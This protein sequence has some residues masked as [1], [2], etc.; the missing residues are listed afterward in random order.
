MNATEILTGLLVVITAIY[1]WTTWRQLAAMREALI[2]TR[3]SNDATDKSN[4]I[5]ERSLELGMR[6]WVVVSINDTPK[7]HDAGGLIIEMSNLGGIPA[8]NGEVWYRF[9]AWET[10]EIPEVIPRGPY[11]ESGIVIGS[12]RTHIITPP[13]ESWSP[14]FRNY[15]ERIVHGGLLVTFYCEVSYFD[16]FGKERKTIAC[17]RHS[18]KTTAFAHQSWVYAPKHNRLE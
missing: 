10:G 13:W 2:E 18:P 1:A 15:E 16:V 11:S 9:D 12:G 14:L 4:E 3:R 8:T 5:A 17:W 6:A 7:D